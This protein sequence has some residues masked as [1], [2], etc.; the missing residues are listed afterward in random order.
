MAIFN[1]Y[2]SLPKG[3]SGCIPLR[4]SH[5]LTCEK[6]LFE[7]Y[8]ISHAQKPWAMG[9]KLLPGHCFRLQGAY[10]STINWCIAFQMLLRSDHFFLAVIVLRFQMLSCSF[11]HSLQIHVTELVSIRVLGSERPR[12]SEFAVETGVRGWGMQMCPGNFHI[13]VGSLVYNRP[14]SAVYIL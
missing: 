4:L 10:S 3:S 1:S 2:V 14:P 5:V 12:G 13:H 9:F 11:P 8:G 7:I 6:Q